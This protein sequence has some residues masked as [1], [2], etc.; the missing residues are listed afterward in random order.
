MS[1]RK[2][3]QEK[4]AHPWRDNIEAIT[5]S[6]AIIVLF[7]YFV[8]E[9][10]QI[11]TGSMQP[12]LMGWED[13]RG[14][15]VKDR[16]LVDKFSY[17]SRDPDRFE[18]AVFKYP[19][20]RSKTFIKRLVGM[21][22]EVLE[23]RDGDLFR[24]EL[25]GELSILRRPK[26]VQRAQLKRLDAGLWRSDEGGWTVVGGEVRAAGPG[27]VTF[28]STPGGVRD[29]YTDGYP[30]KLAAR[31]RVQGKGSGERSVGDLR[32][33]GRAEARAECVEVRLEFHEG[34]RTYTLRFPGPAAPADAR[35]A[36]EVRD[37]S[38]EVPAQEASAA[39]PWRLPAGDGVSIA[40][41]NLD[42][43]LE[44]EVDGD[45][46]VEL[47]VPGIAAA[48]NARIS[49]S[50]VGAGADFRDL[51]VHRDIYYRAGGRSRWEIPDGHYVVLGDNTQDSSDSR[52]WTLD[53]FELPDEEGRPRTV[54]GNQ[55][56][57]ENPRR[58]RGDGEAS[59]LF[60]RDELGELWV[61]PLSE[62]QPLEE[63]PWPFVAREFVLGRAV[64]VVWPL[65]PGL[66]V[67][68]LQWV[69]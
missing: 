42:D 57:G 51:E 23:I 16:V 26:P 3:K 32:F 64:L 60:F 2:K 62:A 58:V 47:D 24:G 7:K 45:V 21:P 13:P 22:N 54:R 68:R 59:R 28:P 38:G 63:E 37:P 61:T 1:R 11:P 65:K 53:R 6:I 49:L 67:Y 41:Q 8:L 19:L 5:V 44:L 31:V 29:H 40:G 4:K 46:L 15:S 43:R 27:R 25:G 20:D 50:A 34:S 9:A 30:P 33:E 17:H 36:I 69:R 66:G 48:T 12:T 35:P 14:G 56:P 10:Y 39:E 55:R 18:V 52:Y